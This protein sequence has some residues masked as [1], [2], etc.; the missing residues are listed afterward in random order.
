MDENDV[1]RIIDLLKK[2]AIFSPLS[3]EELRIIAENSEFTHFTANETIFHQNDPGTELYI[4]E[5]G[6]VILSRA[7]PYE[8]EI[9][10]AR[11]I[12]GDIFGEMDLLQE[13]LRNVRAWVEE[14]ARLLRFPKRGRDFREVLREYPEIAAQLLHKFLVVIAGR[15]R[16]TNGLIKENSPVVQELKKQVYTDK[17]T[18]L[19]NKTF[20]EENT[21]SYTQDLSKP[22]ALLSMKPDNFK[23]INDT[24]GHEAGDRTIQIMAAKLQTLV[25]GEALLIRYMGNELMVLLPKADRERSLRFAEQLRQQMTD[26]DVTEVTGGEEFHLSVSIGI[27]LYPDHAESPLEFIERAHEL[28]LVGRAMGGNKILFP[29]DKKEGREEG[30]V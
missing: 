5:S 14:E 29:E 19:G 12:E 7:E 11:F 30:T 6:E 13:T 25:E 17:L 27:A 20:L 4:V 8:K 28:P 26:L 10:I 3:E 23:L 21:G 1:P 16:S 9:D 15:I 18:G 22:A 24:Y 2:A